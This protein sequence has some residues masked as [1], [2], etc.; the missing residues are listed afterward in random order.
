MLG[1]APEEPGARA[2]QVWTTIVMRGR[3]P[4]TVEFPIEIEDTAP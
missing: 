3:H 1:D 2:R 4:E